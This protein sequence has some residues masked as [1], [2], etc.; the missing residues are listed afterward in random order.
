MINCDFSNNLLI[1]DQLFTKCNTD[2]LVIFGN[3]KIKN[4]NAFLSRWDSELLNCLIWF[5][6]MHCNYLFLFISLFCRLYPVLSHY[7][8]VETLKICTHWALHVVIGQSYLE[9]M[10]CLSNPNWEVWLVCLESNTISDK[11]TKHHLRTVHEVEHH[12]F[13][14]WH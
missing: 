5:I 13:K 9:V 2:L 12:I 14:L 7:V 10:V 6:V 8:L 4:F 3:T 11:W 1:L